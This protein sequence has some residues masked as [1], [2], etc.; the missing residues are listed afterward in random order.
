MKSDLGATGMQAGGDH[1]LE[2]GSLEGGWRRW[3]L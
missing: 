1:T 2:G 3:H